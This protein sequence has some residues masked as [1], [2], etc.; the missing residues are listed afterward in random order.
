MKKFIVVDIVCALIL[1]AILTAYNEAK[2]CDMRCKMDR[3]DG[4][5]IV[6]LVMK[7]EWE[8]AKCFQFAL[9]EINKKKETTISRFFDWLIGEN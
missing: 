9:R 7:P 2:S 1:L 8:Y 5:T 6:C 3:I 4:I